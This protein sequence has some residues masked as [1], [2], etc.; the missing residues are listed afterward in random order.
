MD[1]GFVNRL[2]PNLRH[3][4]FEEKEIQINGGEGCV[5]SLFGVQKAFADRKENA[6]PDELLHVLLRAVEAMKNP[7]LLGFVLFS[8]GDDFV[9][10]AHIVENHRLVQSFRKRD[11]MLEKGDLS[12]ESGLVHLIQTRLTE[13]NH[14]R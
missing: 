2:N 4:G 11:L 3:V 7:G 14:I 10:T 9:M 13:G 12:F 6:L 5:D 1:G 8:H